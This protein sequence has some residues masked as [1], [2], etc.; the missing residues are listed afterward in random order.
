MPKGKATRPRVYA[1]LRPMFGRDAGQDPLFHVE[2]GSTLEYKREE[3]ADVSRFTF[4]KVFGM[5]STQ[6][7]VFAEI[8]DV[9]LDSLRKG[10]NSTILAYGQ[11]GSGK[12]FSMEG[13]KDSATGQYTSRGLIPRLFEA[14]FALFANDPT[15]KSYQVSLQFIELYNEQ[16]QDLL[17]NRKVV[18]VSGDPTGGYQCREAVRHVCKDPA[19]AQAVYNKG[20]SMRATASTKMNEASSRSHALL[21]L[22]VAWTEQK[23]KS[24]A[25]LNLVDLAGSEGMKKTGA[26]GKNAKEGIKI[27]LSLTKLALTVKCLA[28]GS[29]H[30]PFRESKLTM[31]L[32]K[33]LGGNN[34]LHII[35]ALSNSR[36][37]VAEGTACLRFGQSCLSM[38]VNPNAN[39]LEK[40][41]AEMK[42]VI[43]E[44]MQ[45]ISSL[46]QEN[47]DLKARL[48][49]ATKVGA[50]R[51]SMGEGEIPD[52]M[53]AKH[54]EVNK[55]ALR[56]DL[57][58][59]AESI[60]ELTAA[61][62]EKRKERDALVA[63]AEGEG[64]DLFIDENAPE[65]AGLT[66]QEKTEA[67]EAR[68]RELMVQR[69]KQVAENEQ[70]QKALE[71]EL[72]QQLELQGK[73]EAR[74]AGADAS[75]ALEEE[76][77]RAEVEEKAAEERR[78]VEAKAAAM[79]AALKAAEVERSRREEERAQREREMQEELAKREETM[80]REEELREQM[81]K[82]SAEENAEM[83]ERMASLVRERQEQEKEIERVRQEAS[84][85]GSLQKEAQ[86]AIEAKRAQEEELAK[87][88][89]QIAQMA[90]DADARAQS[91]ASLQSQLGG[92][93]QVYESAEV[94][95]QKAEVRLARKA[96]KSKA[97]P[98]A[99]SQILATLPVLSACNDL[100][101]LTDLE[102]ANRSMFQGLGGVHRLV[103]YLRPKGQN[104]PYATI[105]ARTL[106]CV[107]DAEG[108]R[109]FH[110]YASGTDADGEVRFR[111]LL[112]LLQSSDPDDKENAC[113]GVAAAAQ[114]SPDNQQAFFEY[115]IAAQ[116]YAVLQE[117]SQLPIPRQRLQRVVV[118]AMAEL[119]NNF[120]PFKDLLCSYEGVP[121]MLSFLTP[122]HDE[123]LIKETL[124]LLGRMTQT[125]AG[126]QGELQRHNAIDRYSNL[127]FAQMHDPQIA[128]LAALAL[129]NLI[130]EVPQCLARIEAHPKYGIIRYELLAS[131]ARALTAS[132]LRAG[133]TEL[134]L[135]GG[136]DFRFW[137]SAV[138]GRWA[139]G[140]A[141]GDR[142]HTTFVENPQFLLR[143][144]AGTNLCVVLIDTEEATREQ[145]RVKSRPL[146][147][148]LCVTAASAETLKTRMKQL[149]LNAAGA[150]PA[151]VHDESGVVQLEPGVQAALDISKTREVNLRCHIKGAAPE[152]AWV[153]VPHVGCS[154]Q[155]SRFVLAV[156]A[157][158]EVKIEQELAPW[159]RRIM[160]S[161][162]TPLCSAPRGI[163]DGL[164]RNCPQFQLINVGD[165]PTPVSAFLSYAERDAARNER[166]KHV[167][168]PPGGMGAEERPLLSLYVM[169][170]R[171]PE[172]RF[173][174]T[175]SPYVEEYVSHSVVTNSWCVSAR[176]L[177]E[178]GD[179]YAI[180]AVMAEGT[181][182][183]VP[184]RLTLFTK[185]DD[186]ST[187]LLKPLSAAAEW[188]VTTL[189]GVTDE[190]GLTQL[191]LLPQP[192]EPS[193]GASAAAGGGGATGG[194]SAQAALVLET[195]VPSAFCSIATDHEGVPHKMLTKYQQQQAVLSVPFNNGS[196][197]TMTTRVINAKQEE[198]AN[199]GVKMYLYS[200]RPMQASPIKPNVFIAHDAQKGLVCRASASQVV[201]GIEEEPDDMRRQASDEQGEQ[202]QRDPKVLQAVIGELE[203][204]RDSLFEFNRGALK[205]GGEAAVLER[206][207]QDNQQL[208]AQKA[209]ME[210]ELREARALAA[211]SG[212]SAAAMAKEAASGGSAGGGG[213]GGGGAD[214]QALLA[215]LDAA[216][217]D[218]QQ[219][220]QAVDEAE[221]QLSQHRRQI[222][223]L[224]AQLQAALAAA[225][226]DVGAA[227]A[228][229]QQ[230]LTEAQRDL[231]AAQMQVMRLEQ[232]AAVAGSSG[233]G[234]GGGSGSAGASQRSQQEYE[235]LEA[236][237]RQ[238]RQ[239]VVDA[240][241]SGACEIQ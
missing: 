31:M 122:S 146:F 139:D 205:G 48:E 198:L 212:A 113:L 166:Y 214:A 229:M 3:S 115:G 16:L 89:E 161:S 190:R 66:P 227:T 197:Y 65:F 83:Q 178:P 157:D 51:S 78:A 11:T 43:K 195:A 106:P 200:T 218:K 101:A 27:N 21:Q 201:Y 176:W 171:V 30:I 155:H 136:A 62:E 207:R 187:V 10:F 186:A 180:L 145:A 211:A 70:E 141:G 55:E 149:D 159:H 79:E 92:D 80:R 67:V 107:M 100:R 17:G 82:A 41:Q 4:D 184:L 199:V 18:E 241:K 91:H 63:A 8:G 234:S 130:S 170:S 15:I 140:N 219:H 232:A 129:V 138:C 6:E 75:K 196:Y 150:R 19:D 105:V 102:A 29:K 213:G 177:L 96:R 20:C 37:Q 85:V 202:L 174:G 163:A 35:L 73:L 237:N 90:R 167:A 57:K 133:S 119:A 175:L 47:E 126:I 225:G 240:P 112:A 230:Q 162:W 124:Q 56:E 97:D 153:V 121:L 95:I 151:S 221:R 224:N 104:A 134:S 165:S 181:T 14:V 60:A 125:N 156:F 5:E 226:G 81:S 111:Y 208:V 143:A 13:A 228:A 61:L 204:Q 192:A 127:L 217:R 49:E 84:R 173:V 32:A 23:G 147:L 179:V 88:R 9:A 110:E 120:E 71:A 144:P 216:E 33:G 233:G 128:E 148:R 154:H 72:Q 76:R 42:A 239:Q 109:L 22:S 220:K 169:K 24:F 36:L 2:N 44:Q 158:R 203:E 99:V 103:D 231:Y 94:M 172:R 7:E 209:A 183:E 53:I 69:M 238:L 1:R 74:L 137:G 26:E 123:Y 39:K 28:E 142:K 77:I 64:S 93:G 40:E 168:D 188:H 52:Y 210:T 116:V 185:P 118:M 68:R 54:I 194:G 87:M 131:M 108:R 34:M 189:E 114:D 59:A 222:E 164:W 223:Q 236:E 58:E 38:T 46:Q 193:A 235:K 132:M 182:H 215:Q 12:T 25:Q 86:A 50:Q 135:S 191:E 160:T 117:Q 45:E 98:E 206:L 152:D